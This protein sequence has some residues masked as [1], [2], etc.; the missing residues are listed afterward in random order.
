[1]CI[2]DS[3]NTAYSDNVLGATSASPV[4]DMSYSVWPTISLDETKMCIRDRP[5]EC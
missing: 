5:C 1:M 4:S 3:F 2:R